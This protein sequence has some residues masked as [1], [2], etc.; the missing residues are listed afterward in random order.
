MSIKIPRKPQDREYLAKNHLIGKIRL[1]S[2]MNEDQIFQEIRS[3]FAIPMKKDSL[4]QFKVL[5][6][7]GGSSKCLILPS[8]S[9]S[10]EWTASAICGKNSKVPIYIMAVDDLLVCSNIFNPM[11]IVCACNV[12]SMIAITYRL[13]I[14]EIQMMKMMTCQQYMLS[15]TSHS[16]TFT[17][18][19]DLSLQVTNP[20]DTDDDLP[21]VHVKVHQPLLIRHTYIEV[22]NVFC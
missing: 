5:Q 22:L 17:D 6:T 1:N 3:V 7:A 14:L 19:H 20:G 18:S 2:S 16:F 4:F 9:D 21:T 8:L 11:T 12:V 15:Y 10:Y 13:L